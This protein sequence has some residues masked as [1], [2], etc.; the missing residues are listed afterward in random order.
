MGES[1]SSSNLEPPWKGL[2]I[3]GLVLIAQTFTDFG[4]K[5]PWND[6]SFTQGTIGL[7]GGILLYLAWFR[8]HFKINGLIP[9]IDRW[10]NPKKGVLHLFILGLIMCLI[11]WLVGG[12]YSSIFP[13]PSG[14]L[15]GLVSLLMLLQ[16]FY[17]WLFFNGFLTEEE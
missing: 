9:T 15:L 17:A 2:A 4:W 11:T 6:V 7:I 5:G 8:W 14:M 12:P 13:R 3:I 1:T 16:A 10:K